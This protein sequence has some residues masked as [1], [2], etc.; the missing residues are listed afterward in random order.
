MQGERR[1]ANRVAAAYCF[2]ILHLQV[3]VVVVDGQQGCRILMM[4]D[5]PL[6]VCAL[7][8]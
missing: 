6:T 3:M 7:I 1:R 4:D 2:T 5:E 8:K